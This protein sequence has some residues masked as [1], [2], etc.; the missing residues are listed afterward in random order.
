MVNGPLAGK[1][2]DIFGIKEQDY[3]VNVTYD[4]VMVACM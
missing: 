1:Y 3:V 2:P 4:L